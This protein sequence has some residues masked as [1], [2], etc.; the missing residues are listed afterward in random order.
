MPPWIRGADQERKADPAQKSVP[1]SG[2][3]LMHGAP[4]FAIVG[5]RL[6]AGILTDGKETR[7]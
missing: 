7:G 2:I 4:R 6:S 3:P 5:N 1:A